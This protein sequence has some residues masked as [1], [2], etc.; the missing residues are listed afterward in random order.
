MEFLDTLAA[1]PAL[2]I[3]CCT[4]LGLMIGSFLN[5]VIYRVPIMMDNALRDECEELHR[6]DAANAALAAGSASAPSPAPEAAA[7]VAAEAV[8]EAATEPVAAA[9]APPPRPPFN[10][11][12][13]RSAC[14]HCKAQITALQNVPVVSWLA[15][16]GKCA[17]CKAP[18]SARY[19]SVELATGVLS[20]FIAWH[21]GFGGLALAA[22]AFTWLLIALTMID[23][24]TQYLPD[25]LTYPL[26]WLGLIVS[27]WHPAWAPGADP[28]GPADSIKGAVAGYLSLWSVYWL[29][30]LV[31][32]KEGMGYGDF[33][34]FAALGAWLGW[35]MLLPIIVFASG[36][37][38]VI[39]LVLM[40]R[41]QKGKEMQI[42]FGPFL[43]I[44]GWLALVFGH[45]IVARYFALFTPHG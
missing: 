6:F 36:V 22:L 23:F 19:P 21:F 25:Q 1:H 12:V 9:E 45:E 3:G 30:K 34:L 28:V 10:F 29:F 16:R 14:P 2:Y 5:V 7:E 33:K 15:L 4:A 40:I 38:A 18:I 41:R 26:L 8:P 31:T 44:A 43:A 24:D 32:G 17:N 13:P 37:G 42:A 35:K 11:V 20:G 27:L 39:G